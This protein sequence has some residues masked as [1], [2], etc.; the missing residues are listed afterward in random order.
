MKLISLN[1]WGGHVEK[2]LLNFIE[3]Y[4]DVDIFCFQEVYRQAPQKISTEDRYHHLDIYSEIAHILIEHEGF[5]RPVV[6][7]IYGVAMFVKRSLD[8]IVEGEVI[9]HDNPDYPGMGPTHRRNL[10]WLECCVQDKNY[11][12][13]NVHGLW[14]G[15]GKTDS[16]DRL[17][18]A[19]HIKDFIDTLNTSVILCGDF[20][21][22]PDTKS[23]TIIESNL[24]NLIKQ[25]NIT[26]TR[27]S[28]YPKDEKFADYV[29]T[30]E[31]VKINDFQVLPEEV[32]DHAALWVD[33]T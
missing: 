13:I 32:S 3:Q 29:L 31:D 1:I 8:V 25:Y 17:A 6:N 19:Q 18:Q 5:F 2:P 23:M 10:Q 22:R 33:F 20:N 26:S 11:F 28:L 15:K 12:I 21:L 24:T 14:N 4:R 7:N 27:T 16:P 30:S 9:I